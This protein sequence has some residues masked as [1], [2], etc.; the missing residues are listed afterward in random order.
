MFNAVPRAVDRDVYDARGCTKE[1]L[2]Y[3]ALTSASVR[4]LNY[5]LVE[6][7]VGVDSAALSARYSI[8]RDGLYYIIIVNCNESNAGIAEL[9]GTVTWYS[10][11]GHL[12][13]SDYF[14]IPSNAAL[15]ALYA[16]ACAAWLA[17]LIVRRDK[18]MLLHHGGI[19]ALL[20]VGSVSHCFA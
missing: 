20:F 8:E 18:L 6:F 13:G 15:S 17:L 3:T 4:H 19:A 1:Q 10:P 14:Y 12:T 5:S 16:V 7:D 9:R 11:L 2:G